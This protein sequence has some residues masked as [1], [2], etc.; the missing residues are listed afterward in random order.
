MSFLIG[1]VV[2]NFVLVFPQLDTQDLIYRF[3]CMMK[4]KNAC[5]HKHWSAQIIS[6]TSVLKNSLQHNIIVAVSEGL[7]VT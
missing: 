1:I 4:S 3:S 5:I 2:I 7:G 6:I